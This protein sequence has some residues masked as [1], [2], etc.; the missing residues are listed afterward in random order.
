MNIV[1]Y[2]HPA[3]RFPA[4]PVTLIDNEL[5]RA[6]GQMLELMYANNGLGL[7]APQ[8]ALPFQ[9]LAL[10]FAGDPKETDQE[11]VVINPVILEQR[12]IIDDEKEGCL[13]FPGLYQIIRRSKSVK[14]RG[15]NLKGQ[16]IEM[17]CT[18]LAA[19]LWQHEID[20]LHGTLFIDKMTAL[21]KR[22]SQDALREFENDYRKAQAKGELAADN[23]LLDE[24]TQ[25]ANQMQ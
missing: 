8:V 25:K 3:L 20:H 17:S 14:V 2:P 22:T 24:L 11:L 6:A 15:Y 7:A 16:L 12:G 9:L 10:N 1:K 18:G 5:H 21:G 13:S 19:R 23:V 4:K